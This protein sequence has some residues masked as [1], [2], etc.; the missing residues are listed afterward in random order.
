MSLLALAMKA[1]FFPSVMPIQRSWHAPFCLLQNTPD[2]GKIEV[3]RSL[4]LFL[5]FC[6]QKACRA[7]R[8]FSSPLFPSTI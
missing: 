7:T 2:W 1:F 3:T 5:I 4:A 8:H 6:I